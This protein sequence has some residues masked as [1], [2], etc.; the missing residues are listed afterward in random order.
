M[1]EKRK[2]G[3]RE[4]KE[5]PWTYRYAQRAH[6]EAGCVVDTSTR[7]TSPPNGS[8][9]EEDVCCCCCGDIGDITN[10][11]TMGSQPFAAGV[12]SLMWN[13]ASVFPDKM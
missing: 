12:A 11:P 2:R 8:R 7:P 13:P 3:E 10:Q 5:V 9:G 6:R 1:N 4:E